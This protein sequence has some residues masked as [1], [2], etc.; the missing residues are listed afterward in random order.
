MHIYTKIKSI[1][2]D[3]KL[4]YTPK[5]GLHRDDIKQ[6]ELYGIDNL[7]YKISIKPT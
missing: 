3:P 4:I 5:I 7:T 2:R 1:L 6:D